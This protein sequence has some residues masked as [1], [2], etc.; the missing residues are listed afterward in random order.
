M[1]FLQDIPTNCFA[2]LLFDNSAAAQNHGVW[3][4]GRGNRAVLLR[5]E[6][7]GCEVQSMDECGSGGWRL[8]TDGAG[9]W[10]TLFV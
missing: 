9:E 4:A 8:Y 1:N 5:C 3:A 2:V 6:V 7:S 10:G